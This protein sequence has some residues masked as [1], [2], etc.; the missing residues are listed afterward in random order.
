MASSKPDTRYAH[1]YEVDNGGQSWYN[2]LALQLRKR[3]SHGLSTGVSYTWSHA[4]DDANQNGASGTI[5]FTQSNLA[6][7]TTGWTRGPRRLT[8]ATAPL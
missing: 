8:S 1:L 4:I 6:P 3:M 2:G 7:A 5:G